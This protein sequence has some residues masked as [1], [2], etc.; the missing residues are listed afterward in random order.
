MERK[1]EEALLRRLQIPGVLGYG[2]CEE[3]EWGNDNGCYS[4][5][6]SDEHNLQITGKPS[7]TPEEELDL[8][9]TFRPDPGT[10]N[11]P[12]VISWEGFEEEE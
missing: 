4:I 10:G 11:L 6:I 2:T 3:D 12:W 7:S 8:Y 1:R 5:D 9:L